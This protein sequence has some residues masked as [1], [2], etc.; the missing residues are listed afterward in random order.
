MMKYFNKSF[1]KFAA[2]FLFLVAIGIIGVIVI[3]GVQV[4]S[5]GEESGAVSITTLQL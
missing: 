2:G 1:F 3:G 5:L 4:E